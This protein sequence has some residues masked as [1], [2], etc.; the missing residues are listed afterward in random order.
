MEAFEAM[1]PWV[2]LLGLIGL[3][4]L[5][6]IRHPIG[7]DRS[8]RF[9]RLVGLGGLLGLSGFWIP[10][11]GAMGAFGSLGLW[12]HQRPTYHRY[13]CLGWLGVA[14]LP[15]LVGAISDLMGR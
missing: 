8:G 3:S 12:N 13:A 6:G 4:G 15:Y 9:I 1:A 11:A 7:A 14:G 2:G 5:L 10:G